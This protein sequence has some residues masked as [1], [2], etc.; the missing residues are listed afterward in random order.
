LANFIPLHHRHAVP[1]GIRNT[2]SLVSSADLR[3]WVVAWVGAA[4]VEFGGAHPKANHR[5]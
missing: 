1:G 3:T 4:G 2:L 5:I